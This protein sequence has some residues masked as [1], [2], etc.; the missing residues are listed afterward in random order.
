MATG[1]SRENSEW[2]VRGENGQLMTRI[3]NG[4]PHDKSGTW[5][6]EEIRN[7]HLENALRIRV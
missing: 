5:T 1:K 7:Y 4:I 6:F 2:Y 3:E